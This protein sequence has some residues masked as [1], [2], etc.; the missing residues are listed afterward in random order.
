MVQSVTTSYD[1]Q[2]IVSQLIALESQ[3]L[4]D[5][6][7]KK[8]TYEGQ[9]DA[10]EE[11]RTSLKALQTALDALRDASTFLSKTATTS[12]EDVLTAE[13]G[14]NA[15]ET[16]Y[17]FSDITLATAATAQSSGAVGLAQG[18]YRSVT[19]G[20]EINTEGGDANF[21]ERIDSGNLDIDSDKSI[22]S[23]TFYVNSEEITVTA[24]DTIMTILGKIN[25]SGA[26]VTAT[27]SGDQVTITQDTVGPNYFVNL[28]DDTT[29]FFD[30]M[31][32]TSGNGN[33]DP[34]GT[35]GEYADYDKDI[36]DTAL[37]VTDG[38]FTINGIT[39]AV[40]V[41]EDSL[42]EL[43]NEINASG[44]GVLA[45]YD[46][47]DDKITLTSSEDGEDI[48]LS[49]DTSGLFAELQIATGSHTG[50]DATVTLNGQTLTRDSNTFEIN[51]TTFTLRGSGTA[52]V[53]VAKDTDTAVEAV[54][55]FVTQYNDTVDLL[56][57]KETDEDSP[58]NGDMKVKSLRRRLRSCVYSGVEN[59]GALSYL[60]EVGLEIEHDTK[61]KTITFDSDELEDALDESANDVFQLFAYNTDSDGLY[62]DGGFAD[63][64]YDYLQDY[65]KQYSG[66]I[67]EHKE[68]IEDRID[69][70]E[71]KIS[72]KEDALARREE[73]LTEE[74]ERLFAVFQQLQTQSTSI[75]TILTQ[76]MSANNTSASALL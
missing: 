59:P 55:A 51:G 7:T 28:E 36:E 42:S 49:N 26:G 44:A 19:S 29:G 8:Q 64:V 24:S 63:D 66:Y 31:K 21:N 58:L 4:E 23:G 54:Q 35:T 2:S 50:T 45:F 76:S 52:S 33:P 13:A 46:N 65:T 47:V 74:Y 12:D 61:A 71:K 62:D 53:T 38:Y 20:E 72:R 9:I 67:T 70:V 32:L 3:P 68:H 40:D 10:W 18:T 22:V 14:T 27:I 39:F 41:S 15:S 6:E 16:T 11:I 34:D 56:Y 25:S 17:T 73:Q 1:I 69:S 60:S 57:S 43:V 48:V 5:L 30:A 75:Y 37:A